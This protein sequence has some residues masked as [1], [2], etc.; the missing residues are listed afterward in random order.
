MLKK[1][2][3]SL[4]FQ[5]FYRANMDRPDRLRGALTASINR[6]PMS[7]ITREPVG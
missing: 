1:A 5:H 2:P 7:E 3:Q 4:I 6:Q